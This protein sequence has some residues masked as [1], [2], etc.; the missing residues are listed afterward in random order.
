[1]SRKIAIGLLLAST[2]VLFGMYSCTK[3]VTVII[4]PSLS[5]IPTNKTISFASDI[6]P[7]ISKSCAMTGCHV[8]GGKSPD[9]SDGKAFGS[10]S[11]GG[12][13]NIANPKSSKIYLSLTG[14]GGLLMPIGSVNNPS[15]LNN[16]ILMWVQQG[17][18][19]N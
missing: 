10:L 2:I 15:N 19:N 13:L 6:V 18:K 14:K 3:D 5:S 11:S 12:Y 16:L 8:T 1:M 7:I 17:A 9:L 4:E